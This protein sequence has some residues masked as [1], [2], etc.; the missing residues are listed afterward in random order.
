MRAVH[1]YKHVPLAWHTAA[2]LKNEHFCPR[3]VVSAQS[4]CP[5]AEPSEL[6]L[7]LKA[8]TLVPGFAIP[9]TSAIVEVPP[10]LMVATTRGP[11][12][13]AG[14]AIAPM[15]NAATDSAP[16]NRFISE[17]TLCPARI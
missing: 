10:P 3:H 6:S 8:N 13:L 4:M 12:A 1:V 5:V 11:A 15:R 14:P 2:R 7:A 16:R 9:K 17:P